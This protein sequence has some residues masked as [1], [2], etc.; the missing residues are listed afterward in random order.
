MWLVTPVCSP[1]EKDR[2]RQDGAGPPQAVG[3]WVPSMW[4]RI[5]SGLI[6]GLGEPQKR[7]GE[8]RHPEPALAL[9]NQA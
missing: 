8:A 2:I 1:D 7:G 3:S 6:G 9:K 4:H 5:A